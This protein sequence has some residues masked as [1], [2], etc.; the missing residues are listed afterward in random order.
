M[1]PAINASV[2]MNSLPIPAIVAAFAAVT[3]LP[4]SV[5]ASGILLFTAALGCVIHADYVQRHNRVRLPRLR[6]APDT[7]DTR[8]SFRGE[9][10]QLAA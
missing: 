8:S 2:I 6:K 1:V 4:F 3:A 10:H 9:E 7:S 5:A